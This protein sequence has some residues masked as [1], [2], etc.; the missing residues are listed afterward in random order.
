MD[1]A[2]ATRPLYTLRGARPG[3]RESAHALV[4]RG[5][6]EARRWRDRWRARRGGDAAHSPGDA[7]G[8]GAESES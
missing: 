3:W 8:D 4:V 1:L 5:R 2:L 6:A 7:G